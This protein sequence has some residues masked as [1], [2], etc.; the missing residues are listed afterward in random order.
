MTDNF[1]ASLSTTTSPRCYLGWE[2]QTKD[3]TADDTASSKFGLWRGCSCT[4]LLSM[5]QPLTLTDAD[6][7]RYAAWVFNL[8]ARA[9]RNT[10]ELIYWFD[11]SDSE[12]ISRL[13]YLT[14]S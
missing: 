13:H 9:M 5:D 10:Q 14:I 6:G 8:S 1:Q 12:H 7:D 3:C 4:D 11:T 2:D